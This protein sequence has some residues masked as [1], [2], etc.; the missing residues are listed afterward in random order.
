MSKRR[1]EWQ[2]WAL[3]TIFATMAALV[4][5]FPAGSTHY[6]MGIFAYFVWVCEKNVSIG[7]SYWGLEEE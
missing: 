7:I 2:C 4:W 6:Q 3:A 1:P 5:F